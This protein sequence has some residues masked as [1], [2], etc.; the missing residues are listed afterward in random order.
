MSRVELDG[1]L[2]AR[3]DMELGHEKGGFALARFPEDG[4]PAV[5]LPAVRG[6]DSAAGRGP[7]S[8]MVLV[9][10]TP[11]PT[12]LLGRSSHSPAFSAAFR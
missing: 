5:N 12:R 7:T 9:V 6:R 2:G 4:I 10:S 11:V 3:R 8:H 1:L